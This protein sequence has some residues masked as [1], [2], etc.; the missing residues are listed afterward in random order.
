[1]VYELTAAVAVQPPPDVFAYVP[2]HSAGMP[3]WLAGLLGA[4][5]YPIVMRHRERASPAIPMMLATLVYTGLFIINFT[6]LDEV[7]INLEH[8][9]NL[10][11]HGRFSFSSAGWTE[12][13]V[14][15]VFY[16]LH[17]P[18]SW[19]QTSLITAN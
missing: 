10:Y 8:A 15:F 14:E 12:G 13:T 3:V 5:L 6:L 4:A 17:A 2:S 16:L 11:H 7:A 19:S 9:W 18:F 1:M